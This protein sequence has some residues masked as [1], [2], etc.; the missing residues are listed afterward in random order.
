MI[1]TALLLASP[2][3]VTFGLLLPVWLAV[4]AFLAKTCTIGLL[5][6]FLWGHEISK[7]I[8]AMRLR[9]YIALGISAIILPAFSWFLFS[10]FAYSEGD[11]VPTI[12]LKAA[13]L[14]LFSLA[15]AF[16]GFRQAR[17]KHSPAS[18]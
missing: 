17:K 18:P 7:K 6:G 11:T 4:M 14:A 16:F 2:V 8:D 13:G 15:G 1:A 12:A 9:H 10:T 5:Y 3:L